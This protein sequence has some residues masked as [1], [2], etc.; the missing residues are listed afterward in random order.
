MLQ[1]AFR[2]SLDAANLYTTRPQLHDLLGRAWEAA[3]VN[4]SAAAHYAVVAKSWSS[5]DAP[6][7]ARA[8]SAR[9]RLV[10]LG[11]SPH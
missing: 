2:G 4:D 1:P 9:A 11:A 8:D 10:A 7:R 5:G 6:F 3:S